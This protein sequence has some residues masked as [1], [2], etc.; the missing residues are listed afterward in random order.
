MQLIA[1]VGMWVHR[2]L[3]FGWVWVCARVHVFLCMSFSSLFTLRYPGIIVISDVGGSY[4]TFEDITA[5]FNYNS[6]KLLDYTAQLTTVF[7]S[8]RAKVLNVFSR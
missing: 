7:P 6:V 5:V 8:F 3:F 1:D 2:T 4:V